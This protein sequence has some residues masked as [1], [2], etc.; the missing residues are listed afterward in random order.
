MNL[1]YHLRT[2]AIRSLRLWKWI[3][4]SW[5]I[6]LLLVSLVVIPFRWQINTMLG[7]SFI[8]G[9]ITDGSIADVFSNQGTGL[10]LII[11]SF[12]GGLFFVILAAFLANIFMNG[13]IFTLLSSSDGKIDAAHFF[14]GAGKNFWS[15][16]VIT[17]L[18]DLIIIIISLLIVGIPVSMATAS[19]S[20]VLYILKLFSC[21]L[22]LILPVLLLVSDYARAWQVVTD[23]KRPLTAIGKGFGN[24]FRHFTGSWTAM[25]IIILI[26]L[27]YVVTVL[28]FTGDTRP[29]SASLI[30]ILFITIQA[31][32][33]IK[34]FLRTW[35]YG[36]VTSMFEKNNLLPDNQMQDPAQ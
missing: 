9:K 5:L 23:R 20:S 30:F 16:L 35:R 12:R 25:I 36:I 10:R 7:S 6:S 4:A 2:G 34:I 15:F 21:V 26:Q 13:G 18:V 8:T 17:I 22:I 3:L 11:S 19:G 33:I 32:I 1:L 29:V 28:K 14:A 24:T 27:G 31:M